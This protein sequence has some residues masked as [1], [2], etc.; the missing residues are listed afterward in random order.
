MTTRDIVKQKI[1]FYAY[2]LPNAKLRNQ[3]IDDVVEAIEQAQQP[4]IAV[5]A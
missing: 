1:D 5:A 4:K 3:I 2:D